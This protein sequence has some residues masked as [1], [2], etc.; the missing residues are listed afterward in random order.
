MIV[1]G[2]LSLLP[3]PLVVGVTSSLPNN[4]VEQYQSITQFI[5]E[6]VRTARRLISSLKSNHPI[7][8]LIFHE[9]G[10]HADVN[11]FRGFLQPC[12]DGVDMGLLSEN[13]LPAIADPGKHI[14]ALAH[15]L[16]ISVIPYSGPSSLMLAL[17][18]SG[19]NGQQFQFHG[20]IPVDSRERKSKLQ[21]LE[22][23]LGKSG[24]QIFI[25]APFRNMKLLKDC[26]STLSPK[27]K[28]CV[29]CDITGPSFSVRTKTIQEWR[30]ESLPDYHKKPAVFLIG[31]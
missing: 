8:G 10:K 14:V 5:C 3:A 23:S 18:S 12:L 24:T 22:R 25:E 11:D 21:E 30:K 27:T 6:N 28:L 29:A 26:L 9:I 20:Y 16:K 17:M 4:V 19:L 2:K 13:G 7:D 1:K 31:S 15:E